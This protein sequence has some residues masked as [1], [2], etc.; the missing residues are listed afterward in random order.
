MKSHKVIFKKYCETI[1]L[2]KKDTIERAVS[3]KGI[4]HIVKDLRVEII[5]ISLLGKMLQFRTW[6]QLYGR[7]LIKKFVVEDKFR[8]IFLCKDKR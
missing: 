4:F 2:H 8:E 5:D 6:S 1:D 3:G 7:I